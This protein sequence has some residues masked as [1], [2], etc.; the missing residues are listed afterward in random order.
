MDQHFLPRYNDV[1]GYDFCRTPLSSSP[2]P[3]SNCFV[4]L[5]ALPPR[6]VSPPGPLDASPLYRPSPHESFRNRSPVNTPNIPL[7]PHGSRGPFYNSPFRLSGPNVSY[8]ESLSGPS[9]GD[10]SCGVNFRQGGNK[11][12]NGTPSNGH[13]FRRGVKRSTP[14]FRQVNCQDLVLPCRVLVEIVESVSGFITANC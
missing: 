12:W 8:G 11:S 6:F 2:F 13:E 4:P 3:L 7:S 9:H 1:K 10:R 5:Q 14:S